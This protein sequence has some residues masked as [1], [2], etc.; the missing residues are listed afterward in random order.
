MEIDGNL[1]ISG[2]ASG[3]YPTVSIRLMVVEDNPGDARLINVFLSDVKSVSIEIQN[4]ERL[5]D[6]I[7][8]L[9]SQPVDAALLDL[10]LP[11]SQG[12]DTITRLYSQAP[13]LPIIVLTG[14]DDEALGLEA[15][16]HGAQDYLVK[17][18]IDGPLLERAIRYAIE[19]RQSERERRTTAARYRSL[20]EILP[21]LLVMADADGRVML[22]NPQAAKMHGFDSPE[23]MI[24]ADLTALYVPE[25]VERVAQ[26]L[27]MLHESGSIRNVEFSLRNLAD[28]TSFP[29][30]Q[31]AVVLYDVEGNASGIVSLA[32]DITERKHAEEVKLAMEAARNANIAKTEFLSRMSHELRTPLNSILGFAQL[33]KMEGLSPEQE[34]SLDYIMKAGKHLLNLI[35]EVLDISRIELGKLS[36]SVEPVNVRELLGECVRMLGTMAGSHRVQLRYDIGQVHEGYVLADRHRLKQVILNL[37]SNSIKYNLAGGKVT[38]TCVEGQGQPAREEGEIAAAG[39]LRISV[40]DTGR[41]I[42]QD[43]VGRLFTPFERLGIEQSGIEG[44]GLGLALSKHL[45]Q[46]MGGTIGADSKEGEGSTFWVELP[47]VAEQVEEQTHLMT[48]PLHLMQIDKPR[49]LLYIEDNLSNLKLVERIL[50]HFPSLQL[51][52]A[53]QG[54]LG[55]DLARLHVPDLILLDLHL[56]DMSGKEVLQKLREDPIT[57]DI[58]VI[59]LTAE[60]SQAHANLPPELNIHAYITKPLDVGYFLETIY[61]VLAD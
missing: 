48:G 28:G 43:K 9:N 12:L 41:G 11:D 53:M 10:S 6:A 58:P 20:F 36:I 13:D 31:N 21:D 32:R 30:E 33:L 23:A 44:T 1:G 45:V 26:M 61:E 5:S 17:G 57:R 38:I 50:G 16:Q 34:E 27:Q 22:A 52:S 4:A 54:G 47:K 46:T 18:H 56:P 24:G 15:I 3:A 29:T 14:L 7:A 60:Q 8:V 35:D 19:R 37:L 39:T 42:A 25:E 49:N 40:A 59:M 55:L 51:M 2:Y